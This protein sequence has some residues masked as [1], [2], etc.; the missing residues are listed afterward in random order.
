[1]VSSYDLRYLCRWIYLRKTI[2]TYIV[3]AARK[4]AAYY[5]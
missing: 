1:M 2:L 5:F 4:K 3:E